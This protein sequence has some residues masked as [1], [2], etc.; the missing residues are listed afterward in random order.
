MGSWD[1][2]S[3]FSFTKECSVEILYSE[4]VF[5]FFL[6]VFNIKCRTDTKAGDIELPVLKNSVFFFKVSL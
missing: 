5:R 2:N 1:C 3:A 4:I 6:C